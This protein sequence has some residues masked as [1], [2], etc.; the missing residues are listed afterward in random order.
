MLFKSVCRS[1][2]L[3]KIE[4]YIRHPHSAGPSNA[5]LIRQSSIF[6]PIITI[7]YDRIKFIMNIS[8]L[9]SDYMFLKLLQTLIIIATIK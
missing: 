8:D 9:Y 5:I 2:L 3:G 7:F 6:L 4:C 1:S